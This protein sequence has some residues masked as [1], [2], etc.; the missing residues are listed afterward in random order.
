MVETLNVSAC[1]LNND[2]VKGEHIIS[3]FRKHIISFLIVLSLVLSTGN[4]I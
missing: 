1:L 2:L 3:F 4:D